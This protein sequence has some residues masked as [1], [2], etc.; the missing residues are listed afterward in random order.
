MKVGHEKKK[1]EKRKKLP[2]L[3]HREVRCDVQTHLN[4]KLCFGILFD[5]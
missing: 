4:V 3:L 1:T 5:V 2:E